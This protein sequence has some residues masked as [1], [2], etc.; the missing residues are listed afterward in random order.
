MADTTFVDGVTLTAADWFN[1]VNR[2]HYT[3][4]GDPSTATD[5]VT[6]L[7]VSRVKVVSFQRDVSTASGNQSVT[8]VG[9]Q[10]KGAIFVMGISGNAARASIGVDDGT[11]AGSI[12]GNAG[13]TVGQF[14]VVN[15]SI[16]ANTT[17]GATAYQ[18]HVTS[19]DSDGFTI[20]WTKT[21]SPTGTITIKALCF[22]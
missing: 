5:V 22:R 2:L 13:G 18:G 21:G 19:W 14:N 8:G 4:L 6:A 17:D 10:P 16:Y 9:F 7:N 1:D 11:T 20:A 12:Y 15:E 3:I